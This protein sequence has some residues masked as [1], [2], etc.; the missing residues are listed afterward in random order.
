M[1][2]LS[3]FCLVERLFL[4]SKKWAKGRQLLDDINGNI[5]TENVLVYSK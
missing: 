4:L 1:K 3:T 2:S 5:Y